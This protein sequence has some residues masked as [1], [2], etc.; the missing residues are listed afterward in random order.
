MDTGLVFLQLSS[1]HKVFPDENYVNLQELSGTAALKGE[2]VSYQI[3]YTS[4]KTRE[5][6]AD[7]SAQADP[8]LKVE[9]RSV[10]FVPSLLPA[11]KDEKD[12]FY[13]RTAPGLYPDVLWPMDGEKKKINLWTCHSLYVTV[14]VPEDM[15]PG[16]YPVR[17][18]FAL[19]EETV[20]K[21]FT[22]R[23]LDAVLPPQELTYTQWFHADCI[24]SYYHLPVFS[25]E[26][27]AM[28]EKFVAMAAHTGINLILTPLFTL[29]LDTEVGRERPT[30][31]LVDVRQLADG[32]YRFGF[33]K[34][35]RW[36]AMCRRCGI[37]RFEMSHLFSQWGT[38][39]T[40]KI[41]AETEEGQ[42]KIFGW[43]TRGNSPE[44]RAF[45]KA[46]LPELTA[47]LKAEN[48][49]DDTFF[50]V[51]DEPNFQR[52]YEAYK[53][54]R[55]ML[56]GLIPAEKLM[57]AISHHEFCDCG[58]VK[59]PVSIICAVEDFFAHG[60]R[61][62]WAYY[63]CGPC[64]R[65]YT[66]RLMAM[67]SGRNRII[68]FQLYRYD[69]HGFLHWGYNFYYSGLSRRMIDPFRETDA[70]ESFQSGDA[71]SVYPAPEG[72]IES[73]RSVVFYEG[74]Q[75]LRACQLLERYIGRDAVIAILEE[76][77]PIRFNEFPR[78]DAGVLAIRERIN[79][80]LAEVLA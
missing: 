12:E 24:A 17:V 39:C 15:E 77:G 35:G 80:K 41:E 8:R 10:G 62:I 44:Y 69:I 59:R 42:K 7:I 53:T 54:Q 45:L 65:G 47:F 50:H 52:D 67:P 20:T 34:L 58:L 63:C 28:I 9:L 11:R 30:V 4:G 75:D 57:D 26:H 38:G 18:S 79:R 22:V 2:R 16:E 31:Q 56:E 76:S 37:H 19:P 1:L 36:I 29:P 13:L 49:Y 32:S 48:A 27:W 46:L 43:H 40:P 66:N 78:T 64:D 68:G 73:L 60:Y 33:E 3:L 21:T 70:D 5:Y 74:L 51:S 61:D 25:E 6:L 55:E 14:T 71:Y 23:V 72:P